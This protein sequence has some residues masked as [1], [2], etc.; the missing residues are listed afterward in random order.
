[1]FVTVCFGPL[2]IQWEVIYRGQLTTPPDTADLLPEKY[3]HIESVINSTCKILNV[4]TRSHT[5]YVE[6]VRVVL[7]YDQK[8]RR[9]YRIILLLHYRTAI[10]LHCL[11][12]F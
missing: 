12:K 4:T 6:A 5:V 9:D 2:I 1:M 11:E 7:K 3:V 8:H 10:L